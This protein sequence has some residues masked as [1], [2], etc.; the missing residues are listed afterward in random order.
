[1]TVQ[2]V[3]IVRT[4]QVLTGNSALQVPT[5][6][7]RTWFVNK[8]AHLVQVVNTAEAQ[9]WQ[10]QQA[11]VVQASIVCLEQL[12]QTLTWRTWH[13]VLPILNTSLSVIFVPVATSVKLAA[14]CLKVFTLLAYGSEM[15]THNVYIK[16]WE[17]LLV[18]WFVTTL[19]FDQRSHDREGLHYQ[20]CLN[21]IR[22]RQLETKFSQGKF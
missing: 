20:R 4:V 18:P 12:P 21:N 5:V 15:K 9:T 1:M 14:L 8:T 17:Y 11:T 2:K 13:S 6:T 19:Y 16:L 22:F 7:R 10:N 3:S